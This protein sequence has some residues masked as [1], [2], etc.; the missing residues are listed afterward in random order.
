[1]SEGQV[2]P[3]AVNIT[4][5]VAVNMPAVSVSNKYDEPLAVPAEAVHV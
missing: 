4:L 3:S 1:L 5:T 2:A